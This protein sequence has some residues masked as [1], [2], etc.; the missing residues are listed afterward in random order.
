MSAPLPGVD[1]RT[2]LWNSMLDAE[3]NQ[4]F[5]HLISTRYARWDRNLKLI[6]AFAASGTVAAWSVWSR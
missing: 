3:M 4:Y 5:W 2:D 1:R 6:I